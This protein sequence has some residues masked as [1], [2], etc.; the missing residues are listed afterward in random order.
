MG[1]V[2]LSSGSDWQNL[3]LAAGWVDN[4]APSGTY[5]PRFVKRAGIVLLGGLIRCTV[6]NSATI[7]TIATLPVGNRP[8]HIGSPTAWGTNG[9]TPIILLPS[10]DLQIYGPVSVGH[11]QWLD[12]EFG[13]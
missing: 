11:V 12:V 13:V 10:G 4:D 1:Y 7:I 8:H 9:N 5:T 6:A 3:P 2:D